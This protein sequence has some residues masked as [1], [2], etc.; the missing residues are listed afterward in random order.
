MVAVIKKSFEL[1]SSVAQPSKS[2]TETTIDRAYIENMC[3]ILVHFLEDIA[4]AAFWQ[5]ATIMTWCAE[6]YQHDS[7]PL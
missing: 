1:Q 6:S 7:G 3:E 2:E 4:D 5:C